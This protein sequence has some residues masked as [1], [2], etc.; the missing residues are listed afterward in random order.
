MGARYLLLRYGP[1][2]RHKREKG[3]ISK[4]YLWDIQE[5]INRSWRITP[6]AVARYADI[7]NFRATRQ[8]MW[9]QPRRDLDK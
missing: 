5:D 7:A 2:A 6:E 3:V 8:T 1:Q 4:A 9:I